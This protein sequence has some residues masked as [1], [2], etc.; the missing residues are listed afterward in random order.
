MTIKAVIFDFDGVLLD[1][2][3]MY[4]TVNQHAAKSIGR[5]LREQEYRDW[6][7]DSVRVAR[8][9]FVGSDET[10]QRYETAYGEVRDQSLAQA[11]L[12][13]QAVPTVR[14]LTGRLPL[15]VASVTPTELILRYLKAA[16]IEQCFTSVLG[17]APGHVTK[18]TILR[19]TLDTLGVAPT[20][21]A[22]VTDTVS[23]IREGQALGLVPIAVTWGFHDRATL[24]AAKPEAVVETFEELLRILKPNA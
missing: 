2:Y 13:A 3:H 5:D 11:T 8:R 15:A 17:L 6:F 21:T 12:F 1:S 4:F 9:A 7:M 14:A 19:E 10:N 24:E 22:F 16:E 18:E 23:D 20:E